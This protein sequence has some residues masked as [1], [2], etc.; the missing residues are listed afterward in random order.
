VVNPANDLAIN[1]CSDLLT[2]VMTMKVS[3]GLE[4]AIMDMLVGTLMDG[5]VTSLLDGFGA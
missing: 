3:L 4:I 5:C 2:L 1:G